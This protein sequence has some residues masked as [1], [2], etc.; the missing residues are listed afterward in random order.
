[1]HPK[2]ESGGIRGQTEIRGQEAVKKLRFAYP[3]RGFQ[4]ANGG[5][6]ICWWRFQLSMI[7]RLTCALRRLTVVHWGSVAA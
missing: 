2:T 4:A 3:Q 5:S 7:S 1:M 6:F